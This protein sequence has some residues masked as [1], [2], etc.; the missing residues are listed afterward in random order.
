MQP[1]EPSSYPR[2]ILIV[3]SGM[4]PQILTETLFALTQKRTP[5]FVPTEVHVLTT[6]SG[7]SHAHLNLLGKA[8]FSRLCRD[9][10]LDASIFDET[11]IHSIQDRDGNGLDDIRSVRDNETAA[12]YITNFIR[13]H[14]ADENAA[15][16]VSLAGGRKTM[17][18]YAGYALSLYGR[19]QDRLSHVLVTEGF[20]GHRDFYYPTRES[21]PI[22]RDGKPTL[23]ARDADV[24]LAEIPFVRL[25]QDIP[26]NLLKGHCSFGEAIDMA[27]RAQQP[28]RLLID[29]KNLEFKVGDISLNKMGGKDL[30]FFVWLLQRH[31]E[32]K[33]PIEGRDLVDYNKELG[34]ELTDLCE[35]L[36][37]RDESLKRQGNPSTFKGLG[38]VIESVERFH[39]I[40]RDAWDT[41]RSD[42][43][44]ALRKQLGETLSERFKLHNFGKRGE[45]RYGFSIEEELIDWTPFD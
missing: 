18:Y 31:L 36:Q 10:G 15:L 32:G 37:Q 20:E 3:V 7:A 27:Q 43:N 21:Q 35:R 2:R 39:G 11:R 8:H 34:D 24:I 6:T 29:L 45:S 30:A 23:D 1:F 19:E 13:Q 38:R 12:D 44:K 17:G 25:R 42:L 9:Y 16:H 41:R 26:E 28:H 4:S 33:P 40:D 5:A 22:D 14:T